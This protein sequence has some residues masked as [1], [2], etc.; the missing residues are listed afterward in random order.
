[1]IK[2]YLFNFIVFLFVFIG[3]FFVLINKSYSDDRVYQAV[4]TD[5]SPSW[6]Y[7]INPPI[8][9]SNSFNNKIGISNT[10]SGSSP[11]PWGWNHN[12]GIYVYDPNNSYFYNNSFLYNISNISSIDIISLGFNFNLLNVS[13]WMGYNFSGPTNGSNNSFVYNYNNINT[14]LNISNSIA[15]NFFNYSIYFPYNVNAYSYNYGNIDN[16]INVNNS[17]IDNLYNFSIST[18][19]GRGSFEVYNYGNIN[20]GIISNNANVNGGGY[21]YAFNAYSNDPN[22]NNVIYQNYGNINNFANLNNTNFSSLFRNQALLVFNPT[23]NIDNVNILNNGNIYSDFNGTNFNSNRL[24]NDGIAIYNVNNLNLFNNGNIFIDTNYDSSFTGFLDSTSAIYLRNVLAGSVVNNGLI[25]IRGNFTGFYNSAGIML[26]NSGSLSPIV[27]DTPVLMDLAFN[28][29]AI[30]LFNSSAIL[31]SFAFYVNGDPNLYLRPIYVDSTSNLN[32]NNTVLHLYVG[33][34]IYLNVPY[35][36][37]EN[38]GNLTGSFSN[39]IIKHFSLNPDITVSWYNNSSNPGII[40]NFNPNNNL[41][42]LNNSFNMNRTKS[43]YLN[44]S[45]NYVFNYRNYII[46]KYFENQYFKNNLSNWNIYKFNFVEFYN[47]KLLDA[48]MNSINLI[49]EKKVS[50]NFRLNLI[51][52]I[53]N[54]D[55]KNN[56]GIYKEK[57]KVFNYGLSAIFNN[58][59]NFIFVNYIRNNYD[60]KYSGLTGVNLNLNENANYNFYID[61]LRIEFNFKNKIDN[62]KNI[63]N[64]FVGFDNYNISNYKYLT[65]VNN[66]LWIREVNFNSKN[67]NKLF[68]GLDYI[69]F[70]KD[71]KEFYHLNFSINYNLSQ[72][73]MNIVE[74]LQNNL[75]NI[76]YKLPKWVFRSSIIYT[77]VDKYKL[78][79]SLDASK[80]YTKYTILFNFIL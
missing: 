39:D 15:N 65:Q 69:D 19:E 12:L 68:L 48:D 78:S 23:D 53:S 77:K 76:N 16:I 66:P 74:N 47:N 9:N 49:A 52:G 10:Y 54:I 21:N 29:R 80:D 20:N 13:S 34:D 35:Y 59:N 36:I 37:V 3:I 30:I 32:F 17:I 42:N 70:I 25:R 4:S 43:Y 56:I 24:S 61:N 45:E 2:L 8:I 50:N 26:D 6:F 73:E 40:F 58:K 7:I 44:F 67:I 63:T 11:N 28:S 41:N 64:Y 27:I 18:F 51:S 5:G 38:D 79:F 71:D 14:S 31:N 46:N 22:F 60:V 57:S 1:M 72:K 33:D 62:N 55:A 75:V